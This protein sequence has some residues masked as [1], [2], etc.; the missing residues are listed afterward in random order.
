LQ[1]ALKDS[2][3]ERTE[4]RK[5][6]MKKMFLI[7]SAYWLGIAADALWAVALFIPSVFGILT[8]NP[9]FN[10][11]IPTRLIMGIGGSLLTGWTILLLWALRK[12]IERRFVILLTAFPVVFG[13][14]VVTLIGILGGGSSNTWILVKTIV[15]M[16]SMITSFLLARKMDADNETQ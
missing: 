13:M 14:F 15:L 1:V 16:I 2:T 7:K 4:K 11:D 10:P 3:T 6:F 9:D 12:P 8:G 5:Y